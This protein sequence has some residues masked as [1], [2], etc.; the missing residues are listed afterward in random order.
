M[1][2]KNAVTRNLRAQFFGRDSSKHW[3]EAPEDITLVFSASKSY[4]VT[5]HL[6]P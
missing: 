3:S 1:T 2:V 6:H 5:N 4:N